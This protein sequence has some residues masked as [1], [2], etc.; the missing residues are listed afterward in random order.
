MDLEANGIVLPKRHS[1]KTICYRPSSP[2]YVIQ[3]V[4]G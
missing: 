3:T 2:R 4:T 1:D